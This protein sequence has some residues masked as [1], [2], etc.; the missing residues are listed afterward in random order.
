MWSFAGA[1][2]ERC[3]LIRHLQKQQIRKLLNVVAITHAIVTQDVAVVPELWRLCGAADLPA[4]PEDGRRAFA[5]APQPAQH[6]ARR[7]RLGI[8]AG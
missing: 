7:V 8:A 2:I 4:V 1:G 5:A 6:R 3:T